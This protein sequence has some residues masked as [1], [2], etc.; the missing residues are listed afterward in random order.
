MTSPL[1]VPT[2]GQAL[3]PAMLTTLWVIADELDEQRVSVRVKDAVWL[4]IPTKR[5]RPASRTDNAWLRECLRR[6]TGLKIEGMYRGEPWGAVII[7]EWHLKEGGSLCRIL[8]PPAAVQALRLPETFAKIEMEAAYRL[9]GPARRLYGALADKKRMGQRHWTYSLE[10]LRLL[11]GV[12]DK[13]SYKRW[14]NFSQWV[15]GP[16]LQEI[17]EFGTVNVTMTPQKRGRSIVAVRFDW[18]WKTIDEARAAE[19][20]S[21]KR[22]VGPDDEGRPDAPSPSATPRQVPAEHKVPTEEQKAKATAMVDE[23]ARK[24]KTVPG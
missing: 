5:L 13:T 14:N 8:V 16:A 24:L 10:E 23:L 15:L 21:E 1:L 12:E 22:A 17:N 4:E 11:F 9:G 20:A 19:M 2:V 18:R 7:A 3:T 6:L